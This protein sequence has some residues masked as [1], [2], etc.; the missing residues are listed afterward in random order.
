LDC[1]RHLIDKGYWSNLS[2]MPGV[3]Q[4]GNRKGQGQVRLRMRDSRGAVPANNR[5]QTLHRRWHGWYLGHLVEAPTDIRLD[6]R[7]DVGPTECDVSGSH[8]SEL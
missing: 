4:Q 8:S 6:K 3:V 2:W 1:H 7:P 5:V